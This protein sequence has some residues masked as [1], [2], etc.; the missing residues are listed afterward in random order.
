M[1]SC[2]VGSFTF[3]R[4]FIHVYFS[5]FIRFRVDVCECLCVCVVIFV[6]S[7]FSGG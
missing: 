5:P 6:K 2:K 3:A 1:N 7:G 4:V